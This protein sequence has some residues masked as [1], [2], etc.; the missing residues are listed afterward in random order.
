M[1]KVKIKSG[2]LNFESLKF[3]L[4]NEFPKVRFWEL[5]NKRLLAEKSNF[6]SCYIYLG[7][8]NVHLLGGFSTMK[9]NIIAALLIVLGGF[10]VP[11]TLYFTIF[12]PGQRRF[13]N[14]IGETIAKKYAKFHLINKT[15]E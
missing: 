2:S 7:R 8:K 5:P 9:A 3:Y 14:Q 6:S 1:V 10:F 12:Y 13:R 15:E 4:V 11:L